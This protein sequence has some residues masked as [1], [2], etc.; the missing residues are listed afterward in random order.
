MTL[1]R[2]PE[3]VRAGAGRRPGRTRRRGTQA[4]A[5]RATISIVRRTSRGMPPATSIVADGYG[6][7]RIAKFDT[8]GKLL[9][10]WGSRGHGAGPVQHAASRIAVDAQGNVYVADRG[11]KR[12]QVFDNE[13]D[14]Q[15]ADRRRGRAVGDL[16]FAGRAPV[17]VQ[18]ELQ[19]H[20]TPG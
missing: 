3:A 17:S 15:A 1:S 9:K 6:N 14:F 13:G 5:C 7:A 10:S 16:H 11:N 2:K 18:L 8:N 20:R 12:I 19:R 4:R